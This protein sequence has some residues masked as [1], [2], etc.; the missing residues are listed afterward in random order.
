MVDKSWAAHLTVHQSKLKP[1]S[2][3]HQSKHLYIYG[4]TSSQK[5]CY[6]KALSI[7]SSLI[8]R[9]KYIC[10]QIDEVVHQK[11]KLMATGHGQCVLVSPLVNLLILIHWN[12]TDASSQQPF[13]ARYLTS[14]SALLPQLQVWEVVKD[15]CSV[16]FKVFLQNVTVITEPIK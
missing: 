6:K 16:S 7:R 11:V 10:R 9:N 14:C 3:A 15:S 13:L 8:I 2:P 5:H 1:P 12:K 4:Q